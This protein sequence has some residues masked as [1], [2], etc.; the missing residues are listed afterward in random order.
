MAPNKQ[1]MAV[2]AATKNYIRRVLE[3]VDTSILVKNGVDLDNLQLWE[4]VVS[5]E[6]PFGYDGRIA[7]MEQMPVSERIAAFIRGDVAEFD[8]SE[9]ERVAREEGMLTLEQKG[10]LAALRG[11]TT[12]EEVGRVI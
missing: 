7:L 9:I 1:T 2:D 11:E 6:Y 12:L 3:G 5:E 4:P 8:T 10:V